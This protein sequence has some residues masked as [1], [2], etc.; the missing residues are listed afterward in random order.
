[1]KK[2][3]TLISIAVLFVFCLWLVLRQ[4]ASTPTPI[5]L[6]PIPPQPTNAV[7]EPIIPSTPPPQPPPSQPATNAFVRPNNIDEDHWNQLM[8]ARQL[9]LLQNQPI[10]F[11][12]R[13]LDQN[14]QPLEGAKLSLKLTRTD[15]KMFETTNFFSRQMGDEVMII[16]LELFSDSNGWIQVVGTNGYFLD[17]RGLSKE[18]YLSKYPDGNFGG[19]HYE[20]NDVRNTYGG[21]IQLT[22]ALDSQKGYILHLQKIEGK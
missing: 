8:L 12:A 11:Y 2:N 16:P 4:P 6:T 10:E 15:E 9:A 14:E 7:I 20:P 13:V 19:V 21:D 17:M 3:I 1:V 5:T 18:G 22:N